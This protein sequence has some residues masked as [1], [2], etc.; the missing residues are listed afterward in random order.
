MY[1]MENN[2]KVL[3]KLSIISPNLISKCKNIIKSL[4][5]EYQP[6]TISLTERDSIQFEHDIKNI[7][8]EFEVFE[9]RINWLL[10]E[11]DYPYG[12]MAITGKIT[13]DDIGTLNDM[14]K[15]TIEN[16]TIHF[17]TRKNNWWL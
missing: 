15:Q 12:N 11:D 3:D 1:A 7:H 2:L 10:S 6:N 5:E 4:E 16:S 9:D 13:E 8:L 17:G 14:I